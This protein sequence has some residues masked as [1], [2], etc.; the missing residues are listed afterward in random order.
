MSPLE[1]TQAVL[2]VSATER[3]VFRTCRRRWELEV[4]ENLEPR[5]PPAFDL[6]F[7]TGIHKAL[8]AYYFNVANSGAFP[9][10]KTTRRRPLEGALSVWDQYHTEVDT[11]LTHELDPTY[12][13]PVLDKWAELGDLGDEMLRGYHQFAKIED[14]F[15]VHAIE[16]HTTPAG[17]SWLKKHWEDREHHAEHSDNGVILHPSGRLLVPILDPKTQLPLKRKPM[18]S[19]RIDLLVNRIDEGMKGLWIIDH[20]TAGSQPSDRGLDF[21]DQV[22]AYCYSVWRWLGVVPRG[23]CFSHLIKKVPKDPRILK[24][25]KLSTAK[26]Q[27]TRADWYRDELIDRGLMRKDGTIKDEAYADVYEALL[28]RGWDPFFRRLEVTRSRNELLAFEARLADEYEDMFDAMMGDLSLYPNFSRM[29]CP[30]CSVAP[31]CQAIEDGSD[32]QGIIES[33]YQ[34]KPDR[35]SEDSLQRTEV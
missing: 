18:L 24:S 10:D 28:S 31:I 27:L 35:K 15:T 21:D 26:D 6:E 3:S 14:R 2:D 22:T 30:S 9:P 11:W 17:E 23:V 7:G 16:G 12:A 20:K 29:W 4:L 33:R 25:G 5:V 19:A 8:E 34:D 1:L 13:D 32:W